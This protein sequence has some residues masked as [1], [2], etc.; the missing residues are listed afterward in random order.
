[1]GAGQIETIYFL[2]HPL[3][4]ELQAQTPEFVAKYAEYLQYEKMVK[5]RW[6]SRI[7]TMKGSEAL[8]IG[9]PG[10]PEGLERYVADHLGSRG[11]IVRD[12]LT[13]Q[14]ELWDTLLSSETKA[15]LGHDLLA[16][17]WKHG[18]NWVSD[19][20][21]QPIIA[22]GWAER[23]RH[24]FNERNLTFDPGTVLTEGWGESFEGCVANYTRF[25]GAY[26]GLAHPIEDIF[27]MTVPD[28]RFLLTARFIERIALDQHTRLYIWEAL[29]GG[30]IAWFHKAI[31]M[32]GEPS[33]FARVPTQELQIQV[34]SRNQLAW[35]TRDSGIKWIDGEL[36]VPVRGAHYIIAQGTDLDQFRNTLTHVTLTEGNGEEQGAL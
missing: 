15:S 2:I 12:V 22:R 13:H 14:P 6:Y 26:L 29:D 1:M 25:L 27:E 9:A 31:A 33:F 21:G 24:T 16:M 4:Y 36:H 30:Y 7:A 19:P 3:C 18:F 32:I 28:A 11:L 35:P 10:C 23:I 5:A 17:Y 8:V 34:H 20:L